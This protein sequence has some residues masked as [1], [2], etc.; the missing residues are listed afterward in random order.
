MSWKASLPPLKAIPVAPKTWWRVHVDVLGPLVMT[1]KGNK[2]VA[3]AVDA[4]TKYTEA[5]RNHF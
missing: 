5:E 1:K 4:F 2:Y 3:I